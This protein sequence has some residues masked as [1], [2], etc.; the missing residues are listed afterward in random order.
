[1]RCL[2]DATRR[3]SQRRQTGAAG[4]REEQGLDNSVAQWQWYCPVSLEDLLLGVACVAPEDLVS[5]IAR[6]QDLDPVLARHA[7]AEIGRRRR[8]VAEWLVI[9]TRN[10]GYDVGDVLRRDVVL[11]RTS[12]QMPRGDARV[13]HLVKAFP[14]EADGIRSRG[15]A[16]KLREHRGYGGAVGPARERRADRRCA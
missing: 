11:V 5:T 8:I 10:D 3:F 6:E 7:R 2:T 13:F 12:A 9:S 16:A 1:R 15:L 14:R 4:Q